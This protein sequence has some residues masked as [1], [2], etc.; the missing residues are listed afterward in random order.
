MIIGIFKDIHSNNLQ[1]IQL[2]EEANFYL[3]Y[4]SLNLADYQI[5]SDK[6]KMDEIGMKTE[7]DKP[8]YSLTSIDLNRQILDILRFS[9][10]EKKGQ[11]QDLRSLFRM[12]KFSSIGRGWNDG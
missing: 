7:E 12:G 3:I 8:L 10:P 1:P 2:I 4:Y 11:E 9:R 5:E 6:T